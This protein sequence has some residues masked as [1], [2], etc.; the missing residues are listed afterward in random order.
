M[1]SPGI[2]ELYEKFMFCNF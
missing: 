2:A 1:T